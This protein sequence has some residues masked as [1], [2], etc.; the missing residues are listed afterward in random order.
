MR[1]Q[2]YNSVGEVIG[3]SI[4]IFSISTRIDCGEAHA[5]IT[6]NA[7]D[8]EKKNCNEYKEKIP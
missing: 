8:T 3:Y 7:N 2:I 4:K 1:L 6:N 5:T